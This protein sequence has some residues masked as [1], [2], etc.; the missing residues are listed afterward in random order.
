M[1]RGLLSASALT[2]ALILLLALNILSGLSLRGARIDLTEDRLYTLTDGTLQVLDELQDEVTLNFYF[3]AEALRDV[4]NIKSYATRVEEL[5]NEYVNHADGRL[6]LNVVDPEPFSDAED[7]AVQFGIRGIPLNDVGEVAYFGLAGVNTTDG[8]EVI[9]FFHPSTEDTLEYE[10]T[11]LIY[12][13]D[14]P[15]KKLVG[16]ISPLPLDGRVPNMPPNAQAGPVWTVLEQVREVFDTRLLRDEQIDRIPDDIDLLMLA[17]PR[18]LSERTLYA[19]DQFVL[20]GGRVLLFYDPF[21]DAEPAR[22]DPFVQS[23]TMPKLPS[24]LGP[25]TEAWGFAIDPEHLVGDAQLARRIA[26]SQNPSAPPVDYLLW[27]DVPEHQLAQDDIITRRL[28]TLSLATTGA[29]VPLPDATTE[30]Q[31]LIQSTPQAMLVPTSEIQTR[32]RPDFQALFANFVPRGEPFVL[33]ARV[34][35]PVST[36]FPDG[37]PEGHQGDAP[38]LSSAREPVNLV[39]FADSDL[40]A[41]RFW[42]QVQDFFGE[43]TLFPFADNGALVINALD[44]LAGSSALISVRSRASYARPFERVREI[45][46]DAEAQ[47]R[48]KEEELQQQLQDTDRRLRELQQPGGE[49]MDS[50]LTSEQ[51]AEIERFLEE[52]VRIRK[53]LRAVQRDLRKDIDRLEAQTRF[54]NIGLVPLVIA[55]AALGVGVWRTRRRRSVSP[56]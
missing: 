39:V 21:S 43:R 12:N 35:G 9:P 48:A 32:T 20:G 16:I 5:L 18:E 10:I 47:F 3:S 24:D 51:Q 55:I 53:E 25:L 27:L 50:Y 17:H 22:R 34:S 13:L 37:P 33:A 15:G 1:N 41:D 40:L 2:L 14:R 11:R 31:P 28:T 38:H 54:M 45:R 6:R 56:A 26:V 44:N 52:K 46:R 42:V 19:I 49:G 23:M 36:A 30:L 4:P 29:I 8:E 7:R